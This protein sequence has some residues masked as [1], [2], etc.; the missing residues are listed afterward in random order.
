M[1]I[2]PGRAMPLR[3]WERALASTSGKQLLA[4]LWVSFALSWLGDASATSIARAVGV[5][6]QA[7]LA[8]VWAGYPIAVF[9]CLAEPRRRVPG[10]IALVVCIAL[11]YSLNVFTYSESGGVLGSTL[12]PIA[13]A[14]LILAPF[15]AASLSLSSAER[16]RIGQSGTS[17]ALAT[18]M[19][20]AL[21]YFGARL[22]ERFR[23]LY[24]GPQTGQAN[25]G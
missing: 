12:A 6:G 3:W 13:G 22:H 8:L 20:F 16:H 7:G 14:A 1:S 4:T 2:D 5:L 17:V 25:S 10:A 18:L 24:A 11:G 19:F 23:R 21:P 15:V 9:A